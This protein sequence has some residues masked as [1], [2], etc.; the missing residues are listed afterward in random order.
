M[1][2][3][4]AV[5]FKLTPPFCRNCA[6]L[7]SGLHSLVTA[8]ARFNFEEFGVFSDRLRNFPPLSR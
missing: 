8:Y 1:H 5:N 4:S 6:A 7:V 2:W 3:Q